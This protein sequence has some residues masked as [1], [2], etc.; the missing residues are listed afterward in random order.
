[1]D[2]EV[3]FFTFELKSE[4]PLKVVFRGIPI[5]ILTE[6]VSKDLQAKSYRVTKVTRMNSRNGPAP[7]VLIEIPR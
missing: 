4:K 6:E 1:M 7:L 2:L 3:Q 5:K